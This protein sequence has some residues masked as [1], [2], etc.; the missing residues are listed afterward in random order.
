VGQHVFRQAEG[1]RRAPGGADAC[2]DEFELGI[3]IPLPQ[4]VAYLLP[5]G[6]VLGDGA[7]HEGDPAGLLF[8]EN[9]VA[10]GQSASG[11]VVRGGV[12]RLCPQAGGQQQDQ[13]E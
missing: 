10:F 7:A 8:R 9:S 3:R 4:V 11:V 5:P 2:I 12:E 1:P 13:K 6:A